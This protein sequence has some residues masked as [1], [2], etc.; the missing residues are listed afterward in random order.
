MFGAKAFRLVWVF[1]KAVV[2][3]KKRE[4]EGIQIKASI[5]VL[6]LALSLD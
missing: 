1:R 3:A 6:R 2:I 4:D 5:M